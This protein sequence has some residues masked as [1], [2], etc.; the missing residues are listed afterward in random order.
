MGAPILIFSDP[1]QPA[2]VE[3]SRTINTN[4]VTCFRTVFDIF[5]LLEKNSLR[6]QKQFGEIIFSFYFVVVPYRNFIIPF[7][8]YYKSTKF[9]DPIQVTKVII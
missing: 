6:K 4:R 9:F 2:R 7:C 1:P 5:T 3:A 8:A